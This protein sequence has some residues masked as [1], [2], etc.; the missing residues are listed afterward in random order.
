MT[1]FAGALGSI[2]DVCHG[3]APADLDAS[4]I[5]G[6]RLHMKNY[7]AVQIVVYAGAGSAND[8]LDIHLLEHTA[9]SGGTSQDLD[10]I[11]DYWHKQEAILDGDEAWSLTTQGAD[12]EI[13][14]VGGAGTSAEEE[15]I[16]SFAVYD[17]QLS[18][19][20]EWISVDI[21]DL[22]SAG[23]KYGCVL[24]IPFNLKTQRTPVNLAQPN[25]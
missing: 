20:Y 5:T 25:A 16:L 14:D 19:G 7:G 10:I 11:T 6:A 17:D 8:D 3:I 22:G 21:E 23:A 12:H 1:T 4:G 13:A 2:I 15:N 9:A 24:Y 18:D